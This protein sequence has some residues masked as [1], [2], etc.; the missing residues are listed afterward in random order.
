M[1]SKEQEL[2]GH[3]KYHKTKEYLLKM[4]KD[5][6]ANTIREALERTPKHKLD[7]ALAW[8]LARCT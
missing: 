1:N 8:A 7:H 2:L 5:E 6:D 4:C 3:L